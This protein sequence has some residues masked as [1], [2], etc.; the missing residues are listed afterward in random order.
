MRTLLALIGLLALSLGNAATSIT[1]QGQLQDGS[2]PFTGTPE[3]E[4]RLYESLAGITQVGSTVVHGAVPVTDG[5]FRVELDFGPV[6]DGTNLFLEVTVEGQP[7]SPREAITA[8]PMAHFAMTPAGPEGPQGPEGASPFELIG[9]DA[10]YTQGNVGIGTSSP[11]A[12][13]EVA[14]RAKFGTGF[15]QVSG[16]NSFVTGGQD[17]FP[18]RAISL[19]SFVGGG[20]RNTAGGTHSFVGGGDDNSAS[21]A[22]SFVGAGRFSQ[23]SGSRS[24]VGGGQTNTADGLN[25]F[26]AG[27]WF[28]KASGEHSFSGGGYSNEASGDRSFVA[29]GSSNTA[30]GSNS[31]IGG[32]VLNSAA[33]ISS[34]AAGDRANAEFDSTFVWGDSSFIPFTST[35]EDQFLIRARGGVGIGTNAPARD[36]HIKQESSTNSEIG[37]QIERSGTSGNNWA[38]YVA[39]SDNLGFRYND[40]LV[41]RIDT[42]GEFATLSDANYK[43][44]IEPLAGALERLVQLEP[45]SYRMIMGSADDPVSFG[46]IAQ[47]VS[48]ILPGAVSE[49]EDTL[50]VYYNQITT[51]NTAALIELN[52]RSLAATQRLNAELNASANRLSK[53]DAKNSELGERVA[54]LEVENIE[55]RQL[56][57]Q[58]AELEARLAALE[59]RL[60]KD[61]QLAGQLR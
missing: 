42:S 4:F 27:G 50:G 48:Q 52:T 39:V 25:S 11:G 7:L 16:L 38:F 30:G 32:G 20:R 40:N 47:Q 2:G 1:Y 5:L 37:L 23:A 21:G 28:N 57:E 43:T 22:D 36:L 56:A 29:G 19:R 10:V 12:T 13:L 51:L 8:A 9:D 46:L 55:L 58:N 17:D 31:F 61:R 24:F 6:F 26:V 49:E 53:L 60:A 18:N 59:S 34:F 41:A 14:G 33:G 45:A 15:N 44:D 54:A 35:A 3:M